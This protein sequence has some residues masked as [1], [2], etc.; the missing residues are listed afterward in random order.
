MLAG[1]PSAA[2]RD[3]RRDFDKL[4]A[5]GDKYLLPLVGALLARIVGEQRRFE[6]AAELTSTAEELADSDDVET[7]AVLKG[8]RARL[9][10]HEGDHARAEQL[11]GEAVELVR[12]IDSPEL[13]ADCLVTLGEVLAVRRPEEAREALRE[14]RDVYVLKGNVVSAERAAALGRDLSSTPATTAHQPS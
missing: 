13:Q 6:E 2:E 4:A 1:D 10:S 14:A 8:V 9:A 12:M 11:A 5:M 7:H 3:L